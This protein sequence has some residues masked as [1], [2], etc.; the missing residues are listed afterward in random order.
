MA[1]SEQARMVVVGSR[2]RGGFAAAVQG[3]VSHHVIRHA[4][5]PVAVV[6][7][8]PPTATAVVVGVDPAV[9][10]P[11]LGSAFEAAVARKLP[12]TVVHAWQFP[13]IAGPGLGVPI[14]GVDVDVIESGHHH[15]I[16]DIVEDWSSKFPDVSVDIRVVRDHPAHAL[17]DASVNSA[18][19]VVGSR[20]HGGF[21]ALLLGSTSAAV[22]AHAHSPVL[23]AR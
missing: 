8:L 14:A 16:T 2:G 12:L 17:I 18:L 6:R 9:P 20:G 4:R 5:G 23:V 3:S 11:A 1:A 15:A 21:T 13:P 7:D 19:T 10:E 22:A